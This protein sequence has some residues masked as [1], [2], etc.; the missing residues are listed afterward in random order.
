MHHQTIY[1]SSERSTPRRLR[2]TVAGVTLLSI[3]IAATSTTLAYAVDA[4]APGTTTTRKPDT[5]TTSAKKPGDGSVKPFIGSPG[6]G[7][8]IRKAAPVPA[9]A[10]AKDGVAV[11]AAKQSGKTAQVRGDPRVNQRNAKV[12]AVATT[13]P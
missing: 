7:N 10:A 4:P 9:K 2:V 6:D 12:S 13:K 11:D 1:R 3:L 5:R 8:G